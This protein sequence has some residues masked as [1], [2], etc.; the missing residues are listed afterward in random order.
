MKKLLL[1]MSALAALALLVPSTGVAQ[2]YYNQYGIYTSQDADPANTN[3]SGATGQ[4]TVYVVIVNPRN[5]HVGFPESTD[6]RDITRVGG[7]EFQI[8]VPTSV[9]ILSSVMAP[10]SVNFHPDPNN[11]L[12]GTNLPITNGVGTCV[13]LLVGAF[14]QVESYFYLAPV[15]RFPSVPGLLAL[16]DY[17]DDFRVNSGYSASG[18]FA[19]P[20][21]GLWPTVPVVPTEDASWG[22]LKSLYR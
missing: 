2:P 8:I 16:T 14:S 4:I 12:A 19:A 22:E 15:N 17:D 18:S 13:T 10:L 1:V 3:Y 9:F 5:Y 11:Y 21:F 20:V 7:F 6:E